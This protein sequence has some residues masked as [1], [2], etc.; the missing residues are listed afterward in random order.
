[1]HSRGY[2]L[3]ETLIVVAIIGI[4]FP[5][6]F[7]MIRSLYSSH[8]YTLARGIALSNSTR[9]LNDITNDIRAA[10]YSENGALPVVSIATSSI[11][12]YTDTDFDRKTEQVR[13]TLVGENLTKS[14]IEPTADA[15]YPPASETTKII[16]RRVENNTAP[17][18]LFRFYDEH[19][20]EIDPASGN[21]IAVK[22]ISTEIVTHGAF[23]NTDVTTSVRGSA[24]IRNLKYI[25]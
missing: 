8:A 23:G 7:L 16:L 13:Y 2:T 15:A 22:R 14:T 9:A 19:G 6:L 5:A 10:S 12:L 20:T 11:V 3:L 25:Y 18:T 4:L 17:T 21:T 24:S 1:M